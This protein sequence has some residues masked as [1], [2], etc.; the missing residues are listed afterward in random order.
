MRGQEGK[1]LDCLGK[2][3]TRW[4]LI[5]PIP[6]IYS[7]AQIEWICRSLEISF[8]HCR[9]A[10]KVI[11]TVFV[12]QTCPEKRTVLEEKG[13]LGMVSLLSGGNRDH[14][15]IFVKT[16]PQLRQHWGGNKSQV[17]IQ[18]L[19]QVMLAEWSKASDLSSDPRYWGRGFEPHTWQREEIF[20]SWDLAQDFINRPTTHT[21]K[22]Q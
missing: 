8:G 1:L 11:L 6:R 3:V 7:N 16:L 15:D 10:K 4:P 18:Y 22:K 17:Q 5:S 14:C 9:L 19:Y 2:K 12:L 20:L 21:I 13:R